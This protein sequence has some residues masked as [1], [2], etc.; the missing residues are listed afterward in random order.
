VAWQIYHGTGTDE[1]YLRLGSP[2]WKM[3]HPN[4]DI[5]GPKWDFEPTS[6][7]PCHNCVD[8]L[9]YVRG[10]RSLK[11]R[12]LSVPKRTRANTSD[13]GRFLIAYNFIPSVSAP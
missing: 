12:L 9:G 11:A 6:V 2:N 13:K 8:A 3:T 10:K 4:T 5:V 7:I 1:G